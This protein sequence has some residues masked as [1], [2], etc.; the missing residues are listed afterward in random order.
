MSTTP[1][2]DPLMSDLLVELWQ[3]QLRSNF[4]LCVAATLFVYDYTLSLTQEIDLIWRSKWT[5]MKCLFLFIRYIGFIDVMGY[6][7]VELGSSVTYTACKGVLYWL[8]CST[9]VVTYVCSTLVFGLRT[10]AIW[11]RSRPSAIIIGLAWMSTV[12]LVSVFT[13]FSM[14]GALPDEGAA[15]FP[16]FIVGCGPAVSPAGASATL[17]LF[18]VVASYEGVVFLMTVLA[19]LKFSLTITNGVLSSMNNS[20]FFV[21]FFIDIAI[22]LILPCRIVLN[23]RQATNSM[24]GWDVTNHTFGDSTDQDAN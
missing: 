13:V 24:N 12:V 18:I 5:P 6:F 20:W 9:A 17:K 19:G 10:W 11:N 14:L 1:T 3:V 4:G 8:L 15:D 2:T 23:L 22:Y 16:G 21:P 7:Y